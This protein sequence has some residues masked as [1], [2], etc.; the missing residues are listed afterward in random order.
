MRI[1]VIG[2]NGQLGSELCEEFRLSGNSVIGFNHSQ[3]EISDLEASNLVLKDINPDLVINTAAMHNVELCEKNP[4]L[5]FKVNSLGARNLAILS[6]DLDFVLF[7][8]STDY[9]FDGIKRSPYQ[10]TDAPFPLNVYGS[11]KLSGE[12][13]IRVIAEKHFI[14]RTSALYGKYQCRAK[15]GLN[16]VTLMLK[17]SK[18]RDEIRVIDDEIVSPTWT[19]VLARQINVLSHSTNFGLYHATSQGFCSWYEFA[20]K[21]F[22][23]AKQRVNVIVA[24]PNEFPAKVLRPKY[25]VLENYNLSTLGLNTMPHWEDGLRQYLSIA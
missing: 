18:E 21:I 19:K 14:L 17:L 6:N 1:V 20:V 12:Y 11:T 23:I 4:V 16:F 2:A 15:S 5:A 8:I 3:L 13:Y 22:A 25:S 10:E 7:H 24:D 9:V